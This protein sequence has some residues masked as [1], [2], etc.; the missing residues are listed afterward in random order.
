MRDVIIIGA[1]PAGLSAAVYGKRA[2]MDVLVIEKEA[3]AGGQIINTY[4]VD[5]YLG[6]KGINGFDMA[7]KFR[8][9]ADQLGTEFRSGEVAGVEMIRPGCPEEGYRVLLKGPEGAEPEAIEGKCVIFATGARHALLG[10]PGEKELIGRGV[11]YCATCDGA[12]FRN[13]TAVVVGGGDVAVEDA[14]YLANLC[15]KVILVHRRDQLRA[16]GALQQ[17][18]LSNEKVEFAWNSVV[19]KIN[20]EQRVASV[21][22][23]DVKTGEERDVETDACFIAVGMVPQNAAAGSIVDLDEKGYIIADEDCRT[24]QYGIFAAGD[25][26]TKKLRQIITAASDGAVCISGV[27]E[28]LQ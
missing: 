26:R 14:L 12:F 25:I 17:Q 22:L 3:A 28:L 10:V 18:I 21:T 11:S 9:H 13:K 19:T 2:A 16:V 4:E 5:N 24:S 7:M 1:G 23:Q 8:E 15:S 27:S 20:G 6:L